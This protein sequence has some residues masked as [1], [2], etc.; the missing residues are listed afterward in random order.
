MRDTN[1]T[2]KSGAA[3]DE[4]AGGLSAARQA[5]LAASP[6]DFKL[7]IKVLT[8]K[9]FGSAGCVLS[10]RVSPTYLGR[11]PLTGSYEYT[12]SVTGGKNGPQIN[13][14]ISRGNDVTINEESASTSS[15][16]AVLTATVTRVTAR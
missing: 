13:T 16:E 5:L 2:D 6:T 15:A 12:Y 11:T 3:V 9:C 8:Q 7:D 10:Y 1:L 14:L 4:V